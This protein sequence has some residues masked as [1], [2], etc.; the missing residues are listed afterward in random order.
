MVMRII[1]KTLTN[2]FLWNTLKKNVRKDVFPRLCNAMSV[3]YNVNC[4]YFCKDDWTI[5]GSIEAQTKTNETHVHPEK[6]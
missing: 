3:I 5:P 1:T 2:D 4:H 6:V